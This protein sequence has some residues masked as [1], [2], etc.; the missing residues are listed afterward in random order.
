[1]QDCVI[2]VH[3]SEWDALPHVL[4]AMAI[5]RTATVWGIDE[6]ACALF[7][8]GRFGGAFSGTVHEISMIGFATMAHQITEHVS[9]S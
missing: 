7:E 4:E 8:D 3:L 9:S 5:T 2:G 6:D 1:M